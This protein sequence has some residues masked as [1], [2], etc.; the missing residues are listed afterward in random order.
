MWEWLKGVKEGFRR[1]ERV[2]RWGYRGLF[3][4]YMRRYVKISRPSEGRIEVRV[5]ASYQSPHGE[6]EAVGERGVTSSISQ[7]V[8]SFKYEIYIFPPTIISEFTPGFP[9]HH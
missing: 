8:S 1:S 9:I 2:I 6:V 3:V 5:F 4:I 7:V